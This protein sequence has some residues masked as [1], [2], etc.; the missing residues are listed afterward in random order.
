MFDKIRFLQVILILSILSF[1]TTKLFAQ[2][3]KVTGRVIELE[4]EG[5]PGVN[6]LEKN[7]N[8]GVVTD[9]N[10][11]FSII[12]SDNKSVLVFSYIGFENQEII[13]GSKTELLIKLQP[14][15]DLLE[16]VVVVGYGT[17]KKV[18]MTGAVA[19]VDFAK[20]SDG[21]AITNVS[22]ALSGL[23]TGVNVMQRSGQPGSDNSS[24]R[25]RGTGTLNNSDPLV[26]VDGFESD[27]NNVN[28][29]DI[30]TISILKDAAASAIYGSR[31]ANGVILVTTK[32]GSTAP[33][34]NYNGLVSFQN[35]INTVEMVDDYAWHMELINEGMENMQRPNQFSQSNIDAWKNAKEIPNELN[36]YGV[37]NY[38]AYPNTNWF[39]EVFDQGVMH[40]HDLS[41][42]GSSDKINYFASLGYLNNEG[43]MDDSGMERFQYRI[44]L[45]SELTDWLTFGTRIYGLQ[46]TKGLGD[47]SR[48]FQFL[49]QTTPGIYPGSEN[50]WGI[51][52]LIVEESSNANNIFEKMARDGHDK[53]F[54]ASAS[55]YAIVKLMDNLTF[56]PN[57]NY[58]P[59]WGDYATWA[60]PRGRWDYVKDLREDKSDL[61]VAQIYNSSFKRKRYTSDL[62]L[63]YNT[64]INSDHSVDVLLG[65]NI[66]YYN[67]NSFNA[68]AK[69]M[70]DWGLH[71]LSTA[72]E[73]V[74][75]NGNQ[76]DWAM[77][78]YFGRAN[79]GYQHKYLFE[80]NIRA[81][82]SSR[83]HPDSRL[84]VFPSFSAGYRLSEESFMSDLSDVFQ[85]IKIRGSWG[86]LGNNSVGNYAWQSTYGLVKQVVGGQPT[87]GLAVTKIGNNYLEWESTTTTNLGLDISLLDQR[88]TGEFDFY[89]KE[90]K[91]ILY[92]PDMYLT[93]GTASGSTQN[94]A[95]IRNRGL[96]INLSWRDRIRNFTYQ[97]KGNISVNDTKVTKF[98]G[99]V[100]RG[101]VDDGNGNVTYSSNVGETIQNG[102]GGIIAEEHML[103]EYFLHT[104]YKGD[105][106]YLG[107]G[108]AEL[109]QGPEDGMIR[110]AYNLKWAENMIS[111]GYSFVGSNIV[112][113]NGLYL[114]DLIYAD[115]NEDGDFG[116]ENDKQFTGK[117]SL[118]KYNFGIQLSSQYKGWDLSMIWGGSAGFHLYWNQDFYNATK[119]VNGHSISKH[120]ASNHF[121][122]DSSNP[123]DLR[124]NQNAKYPRL[125]DATERNNG[126][127]S[128]FWLYDASFIK[129]RNLQLGYRLPKRWVEP[130][131]IDKI[132]LYFS[133]EN[134]LT[135]TDYPGMDP[136][137]GA[138]VNYPTLRQMAFGVQIQF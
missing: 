68:T 32:K 127:Q 84:G 42:S 96:E 52:A 117:S 60:V 131:N 8:N 21:R 130:L 113:P 110:N 94:L 71:E 116:N 40:K 85:N 34:V 48:G 120:I 106:K 47:I 103:G 118:P 73:V 41:I 2:K 121:F 69:G 82:Q 119:T 138:S 27:M 6:I 75:A 137:I 17:Q 125:T 132:R 89:N 28:P 62:L 54:R 59:E 58:S 18:N 24:I 12:V 22:S 23:A 134:L 16:E 92:V 63:R 53:M 77:V 115:N 36:E 3:I 102:F 80:F 122:Y 20:D 72:T 19:T 43:V 70:A 97:I 76:T 38:I 111:Q 88:L 95:S 5:L 90:T 114:G 87:T 126:L 135:I 39:D 133:G 112:S 56:E 129:L 65:N 46:Q 25:I 78:S 26:L 136:E 30:A 81:D 35:P 91:G 50:K 99:L 83:F 128:D 11:D 67:D 66:S 45:E 9:L 44:N 4:G 1:G 51:P 10:G 108:K 107:S 15:D 79:Y 123:S 104:L 49:Y 13:I 105:G 29:N 14:F 64:E 61:G 31:A 55:V 7:T 74:N 33:R 100:E 93:M 101:W 124:T 98:R 109:N 86:Q 57:L 37:P